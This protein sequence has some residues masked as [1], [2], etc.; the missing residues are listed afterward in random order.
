[1]S[2]E[3]RRS[4]WR[5]CLPPQPPQCRVAPQYGVGPTWASRGRIQPRRRELSTETARRATA[6]PLPG[7]R[8]RQGKA[9]P[10]HSPAELTARAIVLFRRR[11]AAVATLEPTTVPHRC[12]TLTGLILAAGLLFPGCPSV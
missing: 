9:A 4:C 10:P 6:A 3:T 12:H 11:T 5:S 8:T 7:N 2:P 1:M